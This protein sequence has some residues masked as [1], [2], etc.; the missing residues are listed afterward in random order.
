MAMTLDLDALDERNRTLDAMA[1]AFKAE[2]EAR[3][4]SGPAT[5]MDFS[6]LKRSLREALAA[7][8][9]SLR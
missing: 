6:A 9:R 2:F 5:P 4:A 1:A 7:R 3:L 8:R